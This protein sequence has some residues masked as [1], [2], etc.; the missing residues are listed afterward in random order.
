M[1]THC[2]RLW[3]EVVTAC[4]SAVQVAHAGKRPSGD[5][6]VRELRSFTA[7]CISRAATVRSQRSSTFH[8][9]FLGNPSDLTPPPP[10][11]SFPVEPA[12]F[13]S[14]AAQFTSQGW[15]F[16][17]LYR[18]A[19]VDHL[20]RDASRSAMLEDEIN[21]LKTLSHDDEAAALAWVQHQP[22]VRPHQIAVM[23]N[24]LWWYRGHIECPEWRLL[25]RCRC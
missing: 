10:S 5:L 12:S 6:A 13:E 15:A 14:V 16:F 18:R 9:N 25:R 20:P 11:A 8:G 22:F 23:G 17:A 2:I 19:P 24:A 7:C 21:G 1:R 3:A 4:L